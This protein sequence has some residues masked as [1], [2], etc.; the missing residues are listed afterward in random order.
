MKM[1]AAGLRFRF[2]AAGTPLDADVTG[3][4]AFRTWFARLVDLFPGITFEVRDIVVA[5]WPWNTTL[6]VRL[7][8]GAG[9]A[10]GLGTRTSP[11]KRFGYGGPDGRGVRPGGSRSTTGA[12]G[13]TGSS[14][15]RA[16]ARGTSGA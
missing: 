3:P 4:Q 1:A 15:R 8:M 14:P 13:S 9:L 6:T 2:P 10:E 16:H 7:G 11:R 5:G 12:P